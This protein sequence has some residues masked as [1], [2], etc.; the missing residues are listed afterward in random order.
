VRTLLLLGC[1]LPALA[2]EYAVLQNGF[3]IHAERHETEGGVVR[4]FT[5]A[6]GIIQLPVASVLG[7]EAEE[8]AS[9]LPL[10][11]PAKQDASKPGPAAP[12]QLVDQAAERH[13]LPPA[14]LHSV[15][16]VESA[17]RPDAVSPKGALGIMQLMPATAARLEAD[18]LDPAQNVDAGARHLHELLLKYKDRPDQVRLALAAY[19]A[20][21][22]AVAR[23]GNVPPF[24]E[25]QLYVE[26][27]LRRYQRSRD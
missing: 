5:R 26:K 14:F 9:A 15:A 13:G 7:F 2:G 20:G 11:V 3:R 19:N 23:Y 1:G 24:R 6:T 22:G 18:P 12:R 21:E 10:P 27:V 25:T 17:Y 4:L 8:A 16:A